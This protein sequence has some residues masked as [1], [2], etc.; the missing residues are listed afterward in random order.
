MCLISREVGRPRRASCNQSVLR[1]FRALLIR[2]ST[3]SGSVLYWCIS[4]HSSSPS[5]S[6]AT[7]A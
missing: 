7:P 2:R 4:E 3:S 1:L 6:S 5:T